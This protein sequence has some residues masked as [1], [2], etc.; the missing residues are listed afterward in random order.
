MRWVVFDYGEVICERTTALPTLAK[1]LGVSAGALEKA[2]WKERN[3]YDLGCSDFDYWHAI[4]KHVGVTVSEPAAAELA[5]IDL[6][7]W[8]RIN[9]ASQQLIQELH[10]SGTP[11]ALL[12]NAPASFATA[13]K[14]Q[15]WVRP[16]Q[17][18]LFSAELGIA[19]PGPE[20]W[21]LLIKQLNAAPTDCLFLDD[22]EDNVAAARAA[23]LTALQWSN[24]VN[25]QTWLAEH[26]VFGG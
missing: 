1:R 5:A 12:S 7:G 20:I 8:H 3:D 11:L 26:G 23:G 10:E 24:A 4:G 18:L 19:K 22:R 13:Y 21:E 6:A 14:Q 17:H 9:P 15:A 2:Y 25:A 16:F